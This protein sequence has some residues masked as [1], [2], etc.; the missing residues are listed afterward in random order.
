MIRGEP[1]GEWL[2][3][4]DGQVLSLTWSPP[5]DRLLVTERVDQGWQLRL[6]E[7]DGFHEG[8][9][10]S[11]PEHPGGVTDW[12]TDGAAFA[13]SGGNSVSA[14][15]KTGR[16][17][18][19]I[20]RSNLA[21]G[22][23]PDGEWFALLGDGRANSRDVIVTNGEV[24]HA[25]ALSEPLYGT[26]V[27]PF[28]REWLIDGSIVISELLTGRSRAWRVVASQSGV[29]VAE[30]NDVSTAI[31]HH[32]RTL[33]R[34]PGATLAR[35]E[36]G[37]SWG[38][39][40]DGE[41]GGGFGWVSVRIEDDRGHVRLYATRSAALLGEERIEVVFGDEQFPQVVMVAPC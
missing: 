29:E 38:E 25:F 21:L 23:S 41:G 4:A 36:L 9:R 35:A 8:A 17:L 3:P 11:S 31:E 7:T 32:D 40:D 39:P 37:L 20:E 10:V 28:R 26:L 19:T 5:G 33:S 14:Y 16:W 30:A 1:G 18:W 13:L 12:R 24:E 6:I 15:A 2:L 22:W 34:D 27:L